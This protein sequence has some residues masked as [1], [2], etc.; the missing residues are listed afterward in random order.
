ML[1]CLALPAVLAE[2]FYLP[3]GRQ[4]LTAVAEELPKLPSNVHKAVANQ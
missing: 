2:G 4:L 1:L 3:M